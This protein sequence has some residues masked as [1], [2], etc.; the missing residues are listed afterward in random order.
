MID[1]GDVH[2]MPVGSM[3]V[4]V[5]GETPNNL[6]SDKLGEFVRQARRHLPMMGVGVLLSAFRIWQVGREVN[7]RPVYSQADR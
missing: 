5:A 3:T 2:C 6:N 1:A 4:M 7:S